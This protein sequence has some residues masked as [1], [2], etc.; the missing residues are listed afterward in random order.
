M[1]QWEK[2]RAGVIK[3][4]KNDAE[5]PFAVMKRLAKMYPPMTLPGL[6]SIAHAIVN[7]TFKEGGAAEKADPRLKKAIAKLCVC[8]VH[9][10]G[11]IAMLVRSHRKLKL[12]DLK[13]HTKEHRENL[14]TE[15]QTAA[16][17]RAKKANKASETELV[18]SPRWPQVESC[19]D[20]NRG[21]RLTKRNRWAF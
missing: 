17:K 16:G 7:G 5:R 2:G 9:T 10:V 13:E 18:T 1:L 12:E 6:S 20:S 21:R 19:G 11:A 8:R 14:V 3:C 4:H 15:R